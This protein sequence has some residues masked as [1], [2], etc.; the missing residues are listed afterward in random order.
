MV[1][2]TPQSSILSAETQLTPLAASRIQV[3]IFDENSELFSTN[4]YD[5]FIQAKSIEP[6]LAKLLVGLIPIRGRAL[7]YEV[8]ALGGKEW[9]IHRR[10]LEKL[11]PTEAASTRLLY[12]VGVAERSLFWKDIRNS[13]R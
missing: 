12:L 3:E 5:T 9:I 8:I 10:L 4:S 11:L 2:H 6:I 13:G 1:V 7:D